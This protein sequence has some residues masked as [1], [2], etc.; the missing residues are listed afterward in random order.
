MLTMPTNGRSS[1]PDLFQP[2]TDYKRIGTLLQ[3]HGEYIRCCFAISIVGSLVNFLHG[4]NRGSVDPRSLAHYLPSRQLLGPDLAR[5]VLENGA[6]T[7]ICRAAFSVGNQLQLC[8]DL[9]QAYAKSSTVGGSALEPLTDAWRR[10]ANACYVLEYIID[11]ALS[12]ADATM[13]KPS[14]LV[15]GPILKQIGAGQHPCVDAQGIV[16]LPGWAERRTVSRKSQVD[17]PAVVISSG[18]PHPV[19][20]NDLS[21]T[22][23]GL[24]G[25]GSVQ[26]GEPVVL[27][28]GPNL[29]YRC[30]VRWSDGHRGGAA[31]E[32]PLH[33]LDLDAILS[34]LNQAKEGTLANGG[35]PAVQAAYNLP[36]LSSSLEK[37]IEFPPGYQYRE[38]D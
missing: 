35:N 25:L 8:C 5:I 21:T 1:Q 19:K 16:S 27:R 22:G 37:Y 10:L 4:P 32:T 6:G 3:L 2:A 26:D 38:R 33:Q 11:G 28:I 29:T 17:I 24:L 12:E 20:I 15:F 9:T 36:P 13:F 14:R 31:F 34:S 18:I 23:V 7:E 30:T